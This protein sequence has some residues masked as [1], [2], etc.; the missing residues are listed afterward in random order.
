MPS[1]ISEREK[2]AGGD[3]A[4]PRQVLVDHINPWDSWLPPFIQDLSS[5]IP[6]KKARRSPMEGVM[7]TYFAGCMQT[8]GIRVSIRRVVG[9]E[10]DSTTQVL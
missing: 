8:R 6:E 10:P 2:R 4:L 9:T 1:R 7:A 3:E 5:S